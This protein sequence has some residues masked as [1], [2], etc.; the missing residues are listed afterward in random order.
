MITEEKMIALCRRAE[1]IAMKHAFKA[2]AVTVTA[3]RF[4]ESNALSL[5]ASRSE[6]DEDETF[7][8]II[9]SDSTLPEAADAIVNA[10]DGYLSVEG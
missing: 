6:D 3:Y 8:Q 7:S 5:Y 2:F 9:Y 4:D 1:E 10:F